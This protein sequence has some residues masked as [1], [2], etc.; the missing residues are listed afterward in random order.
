MQRIADGVWP[1]GRRA[2]ERAATSRPISACR[3]GTVRKALDELAAENL[4]VRRQGKG[5]YRR[6]PR[7][8]AHPVPVLQARSPIRASASFPTAA[9]S[10]SRVARRRCGR[11]AHPRPAQGRRVVRL[12]RVRSLAGRVCIFERIVLPKALFPGLEKRELPQQSLRALSLRVRRHHRARGRTAEGGGGDAGARRSISAC[13]SARRCSRSTAPPRDRRRAGRMA[14]L[15]LPHRRVPLPVRPAV[16][17]GKIA[18]RSA[19]AWATAR[20][21]IL[22]T[23]RRATRGCPPYDFLV[24]ER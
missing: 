3:Q 16:R 17:V 15:A 14:R 5:T 1:A 7:R 22:P 21:A 23:R 10:P 13:R 2:A 20:E 24:G 19:S 4:V 6:A 11:G 18:F 12:E 8:C 9:S